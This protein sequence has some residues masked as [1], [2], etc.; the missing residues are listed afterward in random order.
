MLWS[1][2]V[3]DLGLE[4]N[5]QRGVGTVFGPDIT[6]VPCSPTDMCCCKCCCM[7][8][9]MTHIHKSW[10][11]QTSWLLLHPVKTFLSIHLSIGLAGQSAC[12]QN[13][14]QPVSE[15]LLSCNCS[16]ACK[17]RALIA[18]LPMQ[19]SKHSMNICPIGHMHVNHVTYHVL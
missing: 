18:V 1:D 2:P 9:D 5:E 8:V 19:L 3:A 13:R 7:L 6:E 16:T 4:L 15:L 14:Q 17:E 12:L 11:Q 10:E